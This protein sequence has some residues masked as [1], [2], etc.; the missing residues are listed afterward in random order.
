MT[1]TP[2]AGVWIRTRSM[3]SILPKHESLLLLHPLFIN[4]L[5]KSVTERAKMCK[6]D[7]WPC[8]ITGTRGTLPAL[9]IRDATASVLPPPSISIHPL[10]FSLVPHVFSSS[11]I[12]QMRAR[13]HSSQRRHT[14]WVKRGRRPPRQKSAPHLC[15]IFHFQ[16]ANRMHNA[17][18]RCRPRTSELRSVTTSKGR[19]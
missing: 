19:R 4:T 10:S 13:L 17:A 11:T 5:L 6:H 3:C 7:P 9:E 2:P 1:A 16:R 18:A 14:D 8:R 12:S 15:L